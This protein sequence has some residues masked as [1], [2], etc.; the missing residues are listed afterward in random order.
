MSPFIPI[1]QL[2]PRDIQDAVR[3]S[4]RDDVSPEVI[5]RFLA[6]IDWSGFPKEDVKRTLSDLTGWTDEYAEGHLSKMAY[7]ARLLS[8]L[9]PQERTTA[10]GRPREIVFT[11]RRQRQAVPHREAEYL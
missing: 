5:G 11:L 3:E 1:S 9:P 10:F 7:A 6:W 2:N 8:L 4:L